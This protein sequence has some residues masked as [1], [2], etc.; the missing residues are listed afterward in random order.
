MYEYNCSEDTV[1]D[2]IRYVIVSTSYERN[3]LDTSFS[4]IEH[5]NKEHKCKLL[6]VWDGQNVNKPDYYTKS[7]II[8]NYTP[9]EHYFMS[10]IIEYQNRLHVNYE[11]TPITF[12]IF[13]T[14]CDD[15]NLNYN[16]HNAFR[17]LS[18][19]ES[20]DFCHIW[21]PYIVD[22]KFFR[23]EFYAVYTNFDAESG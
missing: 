3:I 19:I 20:L 14:I 7:W 4:V 21:S 6:L 16:G 15:S 11:C 17:I 10:A 8:N 22:F 23:K 5:F 1:Y 18:D 9:Q 13:E 12:M 2:N